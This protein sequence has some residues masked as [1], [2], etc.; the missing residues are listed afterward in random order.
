[1]KIDTQ[2]CP[3]PKSNF[4]HVI[5]WLYLVG[6]GLIASMS[7][8]SAVIYTS[9][10][11]GATLPTATTGTTADPKWS[12]GGTAGTFSANVNAGVLNASTITDNAS[13]QWWALGTTTGG[14]PFSGSTSS[15]WNTS[16]ATIDFNLQVTAASGGNLA[17]GNGFMLQLTDKNNLFYSLYIGTTT[18]TYTTSA[19]T[20]TS[21]TTASLGIDTMSYNLYR[22]ALEG[23]KL[24]LYVQGVANPIFNLV[25]GISLGVTRNAMIIG[26]GS[27]AESGT[28]NLD[29]MNWSNTTAEFLSPVPEPGSVALVGFGLFSSLLFMRRSGKRQA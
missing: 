20:S 13:V 12:L 5:L 1:M 15:A 17:T 22:V 26:D 14:V 19:T 25:S 29:Y 24:S 3:Y 16:T 8:S 9:T 2:N 21:V 27:S 18:I 23:G 6:G 28:Y 7:T 4:R 11:D 10:Y